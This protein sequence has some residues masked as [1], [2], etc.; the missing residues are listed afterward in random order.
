MRAE[1][2][3]TAWNKGRPMLASTKRKLSQA[4]KQKWKDA[5]HRASVSAKLKVLASSY[6]VV[7]LLC[8]NNTFSL[9][10]ISAHVKFSQEFLPTH[11]VVLS[12]WQLLHGV[13]CGFQLCGW[14]ITL[15]RADQPAV[16]LI[17][18]CWMRMSA[19]GYRA[20]E[21]GAHIE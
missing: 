21:Q 12:V 11:A 8:C 19:A 2:A 20:L 5:E 7:G 14:Q 15:R 1:P 4:L 18:P 10:I 17:Q 13:S 3:R 16:M 9:H 6:M